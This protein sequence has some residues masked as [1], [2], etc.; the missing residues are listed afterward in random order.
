MSDCPVPT[1][2]EL[3]LPKKFRANNVVCNFKLH[4]NV[5][6]K[7]ENLNNLFSHMPSFAGK[8]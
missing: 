5:C 3:F 1:M 4:V 8:E 6:E 7:F 2:M